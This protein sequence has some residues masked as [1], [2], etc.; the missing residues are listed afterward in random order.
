MSLGFVPRSVAK[1]KSTAEAA[2]SRHQGNALV[3]STIV[4]VIDTELP[5]SLQS[6][7]TE[8]K[9]YEEELALLLEC[10]LS[11]YALWFQP[12]LQRY[13]ASVST[14]GCPCFLISPTFSPRLITSFQIFLWSVS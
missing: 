3:T 9:F 12:D 13:A 11:N 1:K 5:T 4:S 7:K 2:S 14:E 10:A 6:K 8:E